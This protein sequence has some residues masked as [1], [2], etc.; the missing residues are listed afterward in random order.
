[1]QPGAGDPIT[2]DLELA[3][4]IIYV[5]SHCGTIRLNV[6]SRIDDAETAPN[7]TVPGP[8]G[9]RQVNIPFGSS[10]GTLIAQSWTESPFFDL[11]FDIAG[12]AAS[13]QAAMGIL[14]AQASDGL[15]ADGYQ[16]IASPGQEFAHDWP[17]DYDFRVRMALNPS[18]AHQT[19]D[20]DFGT[21]GIVVANIGIPEPGSAGLALMLLATV[22]L[23]RNRKRKAMD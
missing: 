13:A 9:K 18:S 22:L 11:W 10:E 5:C 6:L 3:D 20:F 12:D 19:L 7:I 17:V 2:A 16:V 8:N 23:S 1:M 15:E 21:S 4:A 14:Q